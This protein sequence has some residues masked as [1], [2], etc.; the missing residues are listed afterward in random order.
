MREIYGAIL[1]VNI[2]G[3]AFIAYMLHDH[4]DIYHDG[5]NDRQRIEVIREPSRNEDVNVEIFG[6]QIYRQS[7]H[8]QKR[9]TWNHP[10]HCP[11]H[12]RHERQDIYIDTRT[13]QHY[14][15]IGNNSYINLSSGRKYCP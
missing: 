2:L 4:N 6:R 1:A 10:S 5:H 8:Y 12:F 14:Q 11:S 3:F 15:Y 13:G 9:G 7:P